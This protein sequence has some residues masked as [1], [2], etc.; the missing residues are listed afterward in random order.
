MEVERR[1]IGRSGR[2]GIERRAP[3]RLAPRE[4]RHHFCD[5]SPDGAAPQ[6]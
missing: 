6:I 2:Q 5:G 4:R 1:L 3:Y